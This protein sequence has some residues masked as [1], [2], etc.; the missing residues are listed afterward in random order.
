MASSN[1]KIVLVTG[2]SSGFGRLAAN[3]IAVIDRVRNEMRHRVGFSD[4]LK[5][6]ALSLEP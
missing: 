1:K 3:A 6:R 4:L 5:P 2:A